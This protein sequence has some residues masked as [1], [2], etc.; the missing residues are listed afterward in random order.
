M[1]VWAR[2]IERRSRGEVKVGAGVRTGAGAA[3][4]A[5]VVGRGPQPAWSRASF[6]FAS[7]S[8]DCKCCSCTASWY[9]G[10]QTQREQRLERR[11]SG[12]APW[13]RRGA[14]AA[15]ARLSSPEGRR[16]HARG[17]LELP[18]ASGRL[19]RGQADACDHCCKRQKTLLSSVLTLAS[20]AS[21]ACLLRRILPI[22]LSPETE[23]ASDESGRRRGAVLDSLALEGADC[24]RSAACFSTRTC[25]GWVGAGAGFVCWLVGWLIRLFFV[26][27][28]Q[29][30][31]N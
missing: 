21:S 25:G 24:E 29:C 15:I 6:C 27:S 22:V 18:A 14:H 16:A 5:G 8:C 30:K 2:I 7:A 20:S 31:E 3:T 13:L 1:R 19:C 17:C 28:I 26:S 10:G 12:V 9:L 11:A 4:G 23:P